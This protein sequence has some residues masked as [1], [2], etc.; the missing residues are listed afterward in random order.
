M[1]RSLLTSYLGAL[2]L[3]S[4]VLFLQK[5]ARGPGVIFDHAKCSPVLAT[6]NTPTWLTRQQSYK[7]GMLF[8]TKVKRKSVLKQISQIRSSDLAVK[9]RTS[10]LA[11]K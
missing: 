11:T 4:D 8:E 6:L 2:K 3:S 9:Y 7:Y 1:L 5:V 10:D